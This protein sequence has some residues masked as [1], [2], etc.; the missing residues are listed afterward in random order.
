MIKSKHKEGAI[1]YDTIKSVG[2]L[3]IG[4]AEMIEYH[5]MW[6]KQLELNMVRFMKN[7]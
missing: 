6:L 1:V 2:N 3:N 7:L 4:E 5:M